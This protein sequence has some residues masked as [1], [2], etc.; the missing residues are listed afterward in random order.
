MKNKGFTLVELIVSFTLT[1]VIVFILFQ[2]I[3][4]LKNI[5]TNN[6][7]ASDLVLKQSSISEM[8]NKDLVSGD[9]GDIVEVIPT[10]SNIKEGAC[11]SLN[12]ETG[13]RELCISITNNTISYNDY[14]FSLVNGS[15]VGDYDV[16]IKT[17]ESNIKTLYIMV[18]ILYK[19]LNDNY[20][21]RIAKSYTDNNTQDFYTITINFEANGGENIE[22]STKSINYKNNTS[23]KVYGLLPYLTNN[24]YNENA[25]QNLEYEFLGWYTSDGNKISED[26]NLPLFYNISTSITLYAH[27]KS[28]LC[29]KKITAQFAT[30]EQYNGQTCNNLCKYVC[31]RPYGEGCSY[32]ASKICP[33]CIQYY[34]C[35]S[36]ITRYDYT[37]VACKSKDFDASGC[38][39][40]EAV[41]ENFYIE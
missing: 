22:F 13:T 25:K 32:E 30:T 35:T 1:M 40:Y 31:D 12:F 5:Y 10:Y 4:T 38:S 39:N 27:W 19:G 15:T 34:G 2:L 37:P 33:P 29:Y 7:V 41:Y 16:Y 21:I 23:N 8:I 26:T 9:L 6:V 18:D 20:G 36:T 24:S 28:K 11:Y 3:I 17:D 14:E